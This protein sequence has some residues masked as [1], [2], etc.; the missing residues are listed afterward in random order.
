MTAKKEAATK[1]DSKAKQGLSTFISVLKAKRRPASVL[2]GLGGVSSCFCI[3][4]SRHFRRA[5]PFAPSAPMFYP[6]SLSKIR[7]C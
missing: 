4:A 5:V 1:E 6:V 3:L 7:L 2:H